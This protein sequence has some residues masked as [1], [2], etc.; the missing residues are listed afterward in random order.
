M[1]DFT[2]QRA[3]GNN[4][5]SDADAEIVN[6]CLKGDTKAYKELVEKYQKP[7]MNL[8]YRL[9]G[10]YSNTEDIAQEVF[11]GAYFGLKD[12]KKQSSFFSWVYGIAVNKCKDYIKIRK[13]RDD[14]PLEAIEN[15][16]TD[17]ATD[18][19]NM[20]RINQALNTLPYEYREAFILKHIEELSYEQMQVILKDSVTALKVRV[21]RAREMLAEKLG[22]D[23]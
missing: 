7:I 12:F 1:Q 14:Q 19:D 3:S 21:H 16:R 18:S 11:A 17:N 5:N 4:F 6:R 13:F 23:K 10:D 8:I 20:K 15:R 2:A 9:T 22:Q